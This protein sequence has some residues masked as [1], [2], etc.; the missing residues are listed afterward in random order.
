MREMPA[1]LD[2]ALQLAIQLES[3]ETAQKR[4]HRDN[5]QRE[6]ALAV[7]PVQSETSAL[8]RG[9][10][11]QPHSTVEELALLV[12]K[13]TEEVAQLRTDH[14]RSGERR[15]QRLRGPVYWNCHRRG[16]LR[17]NC[18]QRD[19]QVSRPWDS[20]RRWP[21]LNWN[22]PVVC[23]GDPLTDTPITTGSAAVESAVTV[24]GLASNREV[25]L[26][27]DTGSA[28][29][30]FRENVWKIVGA[31]LELTRITKPVVAANRFP[32][33]R[34]AKEILGPLLQTMQ[35]HKYIPVVGDYFSK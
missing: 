16:D 9:S 11:N 23:M 10:G 25:T 32:M 19:A 27:V 29:T 3:V 15:E 4:L 21:N 31:Q 14:E 8:Q 7:E 12:R 33:Q 5:S 17:Y 18:T 26:L 30:I 13:L 20:Q 24:Q 28:V 1:T 35:G 22:G 2:K 34:I 6:E